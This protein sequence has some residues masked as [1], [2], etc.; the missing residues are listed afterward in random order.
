MR[1]NSGFQLATWGIGQD[2]YAPDSYES[3]FG[4]PKVWARRHWHNAKGLGG[5]SRPVGE[6][7]PF[8]SG[9]PL[10]FGVAAGPESDLP[11]AR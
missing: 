1:E 3:K 6:H 9:Y 10:L 2:S 4:L 8:A 7:S 11:E 5:V